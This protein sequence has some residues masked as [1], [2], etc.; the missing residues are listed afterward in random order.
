[1]TRILK[2]CFYAQMVGQTWAV[3]PLCSHILLGEQDLL[4]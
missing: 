4:V 2:Y 3:Q 1:M